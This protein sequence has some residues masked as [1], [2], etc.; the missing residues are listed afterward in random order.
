MNFKSYPFQFGLRLLGI[1]ST[2]ALGIFV[3]QRFK[4]FFTILVLLILLLAQIWDFWRYQ[5]SLIRETKKFLEAARFGDFST[6]FDLASKG[7]IFADLE[8][9]FML[10]LGQ[11]KK[12]KVNQD[13]QEELLEQILKN[14]NLGIIGIN[15]KKE[16]FLIN[17]K[18]QETLDIP[19]FQK[20]ERLS[21]R[22][23]ALKSL[24]G[25]FNFT[26]RKLWQHHSKGKKVE[27]YID[28]QHIILKDETFHLLSISNLH[29]EVEEKEIAAWHKLI[30]I[31]AHEVMNSVTPVVSLSE[32]VSSMLVNEE[33]VAKKLT[34]LAEQDLDD[35]REAC[36]TIVRR[37]K[38]MLNFVDEYRKLTQLPAPTKEV[39]SIKAL[40]ENCVSLMQ[41]IAKEQNCLIRYE[42]NQPRLAIHADRK[43]IEQVLVNL[44]KNAI[45]AINKTQGGEVVLSAKLSD[46]GV[47]VKVQDNGEGIE[48]DLINQ[49]FVP[50]FSTR[51]NGSG[52]GLSLSKNIMKMHEGDLKVQSQEGLGTSFIMLFKE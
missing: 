46:H 37:S 36:T 28:L 9:E 43:M 38:G 31:L 13:N 32:T 40:F 49:I 41:S 16:I 35:I 27:L 33:G 11:L 44:V 14:I 21:D 17:E 48:E 24:I 42:L 15:E 7:G 18:A 22:I 50:F 30:R 34:E 25:D 29:K 3:E 1:I 19:P 4:L 26:G 51:K 2:I 39:V 23:P 10:L 6:R 52:I 47:I 45:A 20:W 8:E 5:S 12:S